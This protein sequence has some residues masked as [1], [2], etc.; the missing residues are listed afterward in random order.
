MHNATLEPQDYRQ[1][2]FGTSRN[3]LLYQFSR[4]QEIFEEYSDRILR[5]PY[6]DL[7]TEQSKVLMTLSQYDQLLLTDLQAYTEIE[8]AELLEA[9]RIM[10]K[11]KL[12]TLSDTKDENDPALQIAPAGSAALDRMRRLL[13]KADEV[14]FTELRE[15]RKTGLQESMRIV[16]DQLQMH[17]N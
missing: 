3:G 16:A 11:R 6:I 7:S 12:V 14:M 15:A 13:Q 1:L 4:L 9:I 2:L 10:A 8:G 5:K 17:A